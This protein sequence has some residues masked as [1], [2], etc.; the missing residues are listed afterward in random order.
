MEAATAQSYVLSVID[1]AFGQDSGT[2]RSFKWLHHQFSLSHESSSSAIC[3]LGNKKASNSCSTFIQY[4]CLI[5]DLS[6]ET[7]FND[8]E[9]P[10][11]MTGDGWMQL[12]SLCTYLNYLV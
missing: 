5:N 1:S 12:Q 11:M 9:S 3:S 4:S 10:L 2:E 8:H 6:P 7:S